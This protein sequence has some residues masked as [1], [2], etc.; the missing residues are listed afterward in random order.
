MKST[1][2]QIENIKKYFDFML[3]NQDKNYNMTA[4]VRGFKLST[5]LFTHLASEK[6]IT[7]RYYDGNK[8]A[9]TLVWNNDES[10]FTKCLDWLREDSKYRAQKNNAIRRRKA[11]NGFN[12]D[13]RVDRF[14]MNMY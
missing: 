4:V 14:V 5:S 9:Y 11:V 8:K 1:E 2:E 12:P 3:K 6:I 7:S 10:I 13:Y